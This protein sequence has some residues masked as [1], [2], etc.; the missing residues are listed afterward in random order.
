MSLGGRTILVA[1]G[2]R[3]IGLAIAARAARDGANVVLAAKTA[4]PHPVLPGTIHTAAETVEAAGGRALAVVCD[5]RDE[6][7]IR[8]TVQQAVSVFGGLDGLVLNASAI[9]LDGTLEIPTRRFD[10]MSAVNQ[11]GTFL[12][13]RACLPHLLRSDNPHILTIS[14]PLEFADHWWGEH[15]A[16]TMMKYSMSLCVR[17]WAQEFGDA[18]VAANAL[19][20]RTTISTAATKMLGEEVFAHSRRPEI[21]ADAAHWILTRDSRECSGNYFI[22]EAVLRSAGI[23]DFDVYAND[24]TKPIFLDL[25]VDEPD[26]HYFRR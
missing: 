7:Q 5:V 20:P 14:P 15:L 26:G 9:S 3:G 1:G 8:S 12:M 22:D 4:E 24:P 13:G 17:G 19:W 10:L 6:A 11:R 25:L 18:G 23:T 2:S 16:W 21:M